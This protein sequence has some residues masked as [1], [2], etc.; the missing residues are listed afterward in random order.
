MN[1]ITTKAGL[2]ALALMPILTAGVAVADSRHTTAQMPRKEGW[3][4]KR[5]QLLNE[6]VK[7]TGQTQLVFIGDSITQGWEREGKAVWDKHYRS[8]E[9]I[10]LGIGGDQT[11]QVLWRLRRGNLKGIRPRAAVVM[12]GV[13]NSFDKFTS[14]KAIAEGI[15][16]I[17]KLVRTKLPRTKILL[18]GILPAGRTP[19]R[20]RRKIAGANRLASRV[21]DGKMIHYLDIGARFLGS[22]RVISREI[23][24][25]YLHLSEKGY[26]IWAK[27]IEPK[28]KTLLGD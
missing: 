25:D 24:P 19:G 27:A 28:L 18:L 13:N 7:Q 6:R 3:W 26:A 10:N 23:M 4:L 12:I 16:A 11:Q 9:A 22:K 5:F 1:R 15:I 20:L 21:A 8:R 2:I 14:S 17:V